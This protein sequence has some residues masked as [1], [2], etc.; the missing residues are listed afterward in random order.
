MLFS[1]LESLS[2]PPLS[3]SCPT[4]SSTL[5]L[6][7]VLTLLLSTQSDDVTLSLYMLCRLRAA[8]RIRSS[9]PCVDDTAFCGLALPLCMPHPAHTPDVAHS[10]TNT[11]RSIMSTGPSDW[12]LCLTF[13]SS[14][15]P[16]A[17]LG[18]YLSKVHVVSITW[19]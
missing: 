7:R 11:S 4:S 19:R 1:S 16:V 14:A 17:D 6:E 5:W 10:V 18:Q 12:S 2:G 9:P 8:S 13:P 15:L 3:G